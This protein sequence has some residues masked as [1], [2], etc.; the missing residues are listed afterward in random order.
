[1]PEQRPTPFFGSKDN[2]QILK[3]KFKIPTRL[4]EWN[5]NTAGSILSSCDIALAPMPSNNPFYRAKDFSK[6]LV[7]MTLGIPVVASNIQSY[8]ELIRHGIDGLIAA[9]SNHWFDQPIA[10]PSYYW[11]QHPLCV[12]KV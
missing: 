8:K 5:I 2:N 12:L 9:N 6:P 10:I 7:Y 4:F 1:M 11:N 3:S